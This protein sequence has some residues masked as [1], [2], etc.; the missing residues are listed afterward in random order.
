MYRVI[1]RTTREVISKHE[2]FSDAMKALYKTTVE[3]CG[4]YFGQET[5]AERNE[6]ISRY[7]ID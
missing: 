1:D 5:H 3:H 4:E 7:T 6:R 2:T